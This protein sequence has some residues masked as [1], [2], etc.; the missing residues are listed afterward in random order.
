MNNYT[1]ISD[2]LL[3]NRIK[4]FSVTEFDKISPYLLNYKKDL[5]SGA[6]NIIMCVF[7]YNIGEENMADDRNITRYALSTDYHVII[8]NILKKVCGELKENYRDNFFMPFCDSSPIPEVHTAASCGLGAIGKHNLLITEDY[9]SYIFLGEII[10]DLD[11]KGS[12]KLN[13]EIKHCESCLKCIEACPSGAITK[14]K[15]FDRTKCI[16]FIT[17]KKGELKDWEIDLIKNNKLIWGCD[18]CQNM[19][20]HN[21]NKKL[22][23]IEEFYE[24]IICRVDN[25]ETEY[26]TKRAFLWRGKE[27]IKRNIDIINKV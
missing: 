22:T 20:I 7:P 27:I 5:I 9:G 13:H 25:S 15:K 14:D 8:L 2:I 16:S 24:D 3:K 6:Q 4:D 19:C 23:H 1:K 10:T 11:I 12:P 26:K 21:K 17:Q 18:I